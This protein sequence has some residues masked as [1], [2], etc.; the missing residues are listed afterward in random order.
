[1]IIFHNHAFATIGFDV[2]L[3]KSIM[4]SSLTPPAVFSSEIVKLIGRQLIVLLQ[5]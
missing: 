4:E 1:M 2:F 3:V 5:I